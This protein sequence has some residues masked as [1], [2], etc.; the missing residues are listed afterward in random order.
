MTTP[1]TAVDTEVRIEH[2]VLIDITLTRFTATGASGTGSTAT[3][4][5]DTQTD[6]PFAA[7]DTIV[8]NGMVPTGYNGTYTVT[9]ATT[10]SVSYAS[11]TTGSMTTAGRISQTYHI[12]NCYKSITH[13]GKTYTALAGFLTVSEIQSNISSTNDDIQVGLSAIPSAY[14]RAIM[15]QPI[16]GGDLSIYRAFFN[17]TTQE[18]IS[19]EIYKRFTGAITNYNIA[20]DIDPNTEAPSITHTITIVA[21]SILGVLENKVTGRRTNPDDLAVIHAEIAN[22]GTD[23]SFDR[24]P[25][26]HNANFDFGRPYT[27]KTAS[28]QTG[29][30]GPMSRVIN[31]VTER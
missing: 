15:G 3:L 21:S 23:P 24:I 19:G 17:Y 4:T 28:S 7:G 9:S 11:A 2:G 10:S 8:I 13:N 1:I 22:S 30:S 29:G 26:L 5:F 14:I 27:A 12:S 31:A 25:T 16:K 6:V 20:E 18:I